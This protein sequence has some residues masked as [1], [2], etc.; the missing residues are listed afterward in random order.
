MKAAFLIN[1]GSAE[2]AFE[3]RETDM[4]SPSQGQV[5]IKVEAFGLNFADVMA[6]L[7]HYKDAPEIPVVLGYDVVGTIESLGNGVKDF[8]PGQRVA[9]MTRFGG[10]AEYALTDA[11]AMVA[12][13]K[14]MEP[15]VA[16]ALVVQGSTAYYCAEEMVRLHEGDHVLI[17]AA[18]GGVGTLLVQ[19]AK[20]RK[21]IVY[22]TAGSEAKLQYLKEQGVQYPINYRKV[23]F[24]EEIKKL[25]GEQGLDVIFDPVGGKS[26]KKGFGLLA[27][28]GRI[29]SFGASQMTTA[30]NFFGKVKVGVGFGIY[31]PAAF[32]S[33]SKSML[34]VNM[35]RLGDERPLILQRVLKETIRF[36]EEGILKPTVGG[37]FSVGQLSGAHHFL[38]SRQSMGKVVVKW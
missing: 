2:E 33:N 8:K 38:E 4:P 21:C 36:Y 20:H 31:H 35:L 28:G 22:G 1:E 9:A 5:L 25:R 7:G 17:H 11:R 6:R 27:A 16:T 19:I 12:I 15:G 23:D 30:K 37:I 10:Y 13:P 24:A 3:I 29:I 14:D 34:G 32:V 26:L 18:A